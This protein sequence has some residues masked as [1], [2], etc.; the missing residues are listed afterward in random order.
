[1]ILINNKYYSLPGLYKIERK[2]YYFYNDLIFFIL[3]IALPSS[4]FALIPQ[5]WF[6]KPGLYDLNLIYLIIGIIYFIFNIGHIPKIIKIPSGKA[7]ILLCLFLIFQI[8]YSYLVKDISLKEIITVFRKNFAWPIGTLGFLLYV[9]SMD[10]YRIERFMRWLLMITFIMCIMYIFSN[11]TGINIWGAETKKPQVFNNEILLQNIYAIPRY[12]VFL[13]IFA[14]IES[15]VDKSFK[16]YYMWIVPLIVTIISFVRNQIIM[17]FVYMITSYII[18]I[19]S[20]LKIQLRK[21]IKQIFLLLIGILILILIFPTHVERLLYKFGFYNVYTHQIIFFQSKINEGTF[22]FRILLIKKAY[23]NTK[24]NLLL[25]NGYKR[26]ARP[27]QYDY[28]LGTDTFIPPVLYTEGLIGF[29]FRWLPLLILTFIAVK[30]IFFQKTKTKLFW[31]V[32]LVL[33][34]TQ[35]INII[36]TDIFIRYNIWYFIFAILALLEYKL[37]KEK[38]TG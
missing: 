1:M 34:P 22:N 31:L 29:F 17:Y 2:K 16:K 8:V 26:V 32:M 10:S 19:I 15:L 9:A 24:D 37:K 6:Y 21:I 28:V 27:G 30:R 36:Q 5:T 23:E 35:F 14:F 4:F 11:I 38:E 3:V 18:I 25:G 20:P 13:F 7:F 33:I 12:I